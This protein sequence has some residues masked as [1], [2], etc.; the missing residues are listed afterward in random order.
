MI[1]MQ[2]AYIGGEVNVLLFQKSP[3]GWTLGSSKETY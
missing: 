2:L 1:L 3:L